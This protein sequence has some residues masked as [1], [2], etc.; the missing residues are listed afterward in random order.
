ML[1]FLSRGAAERGSRGVA[2]FFHAELLRARAEPLSFSRG[3]AE[4][5]MKLTH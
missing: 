4:N 5:K 2:E 1:S 3:A